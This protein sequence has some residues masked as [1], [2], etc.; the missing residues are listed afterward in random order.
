MNHDGVSVTALMVLVAFAVERVTKGILFLL[1]PVKAWQRFL[2]GPPSIDDR[3]REA[4]R[5]QKLAYFAFAGILALIVVLASPKMRVLYALDMN[6]P[7]LLDAG[8]TWLVLVAG[9]DRIGDLVQDKRG[10]VVE[11]PPKPLQVEGTLILKEDRAKS[12]AA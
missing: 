8:L 12:Q 4:E 3:A 7:M 10:A 9:A 5:R 6:A 2:S 11:K 1:T